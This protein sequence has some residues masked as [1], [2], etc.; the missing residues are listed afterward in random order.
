M[1]NYYAEISR[2][3]RQSDFLIN[4]VL[5]IEGNTLDL[6]KIDIKFSGTFQCNFM[7]Q[8]YKRLDLFMEGDANIIHDREKKLVYCKVEK[9]KK[10]G[11]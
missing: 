8:F 11:L 7:K 3:I 1:A 5:Y 10:E 4:E 2:A 9:A 6:R